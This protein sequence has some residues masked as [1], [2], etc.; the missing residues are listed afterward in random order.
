MIRQE[1]SNNTEGISHGENTTDYQNEQ[2]TVNENQQ[3]NIVA[4]NENGGTYPVLQKVACGFSS[5]VEQQGSTSSA[6]H[7]NSFQ[8][9]PQHS[10]PE[11]E[12]RGEADFATLRQMAPYSQY[13]SQGAAS[14]D[15]VNTDGTIPRVQYPEPT[16][17]PYSIE[18]QPSYPQQNEGIYNT[19]MPSYHN[20]GPVG[21]P[22]SVG[23]ALPHPSPPAQQPAFAVSTN[24]GSKACVYLCNRDLWAKFHQHTC[25]MIITKQGR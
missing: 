20:S 10:S 4:Q 11:N 14:P 13:C 19:N 23:T 22:P 25:E 24:P 12:G 17:P 9:P 18:Q 1:G 21:Q 5:P 6:E 15:C 8:S 2:Y 7:N 3:Q 16:C